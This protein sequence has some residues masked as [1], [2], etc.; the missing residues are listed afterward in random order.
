MESDEDVLIVYDTTKALA[1]AKSLL[2]SVFDAGNLQR[3]SRL[4][5]KDML[6]VLGQEKFISFIS[7]LSNCS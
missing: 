1:S 6:R 5:M 2:P 3:F 4:Y 7:Y